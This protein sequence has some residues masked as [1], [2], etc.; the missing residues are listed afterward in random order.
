MQLAEWLIRQQS[1]SYLGKLGSDKEEKLRT[2]GLRLDERPF[3]Q[4]QD[5]FEV[6]AKS[7][8]YCRNVDLVFYS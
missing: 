2:I 1:L 4:W 5:Y 7:V 6:K 8:S 3:F